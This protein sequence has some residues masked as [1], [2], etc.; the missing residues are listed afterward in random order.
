MQV[1][2]RQEGESRVLK[3]RQERFVES[4]FNGTNKMAFSN[5]NDVWPIPVSIV[6]SFNPFSPTHQAI[7]TEQEMELSVNEIWEGEWVKLNPEYSNFY[8]VHYSDDMLDKFGI[9]IEE[10]LLA[11]MDRLNLVDDLFA[12]IRTGHVSTEV[13]LRFLWSYQNEDNPN[14]W[15]VI[16]SAL[17]DIDI[18]ISS[19]DSKN[20]TIRQKYRKFGQEFLNK[21]YLKLGWYPETNAPPVGQK[22]RVDDFAQNRLRENI[23]CLMGQFKATN[24]TEVAVKKFQDYLNGESDLPV[25]LLECVFRSFS[26]FAPSPNQ[27]TLEQLFKVSLH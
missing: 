17:N 14:V 10:K 18:L 7:I 25:G 22:M 6:N 27:T 1:E 26:S 15:A 11:P 21:M 19:V 20:D 24:F 12:L 2:E 3:L 16:V 5:E 9:S 8:R 4:S 23:L 13:G